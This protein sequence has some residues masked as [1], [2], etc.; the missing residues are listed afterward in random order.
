MPG[1]LSLLQPQVRHILIDEARCQGLEMEGNLVALLFRMAHSGSPAEFSVALEKLNKLIKNNAELTHSV[2]FWLNAMLRKRGI[3]I[4]LEGNNLEGDWAM[5]YK[6]GIELWME[7]K[8][9]EWLQEGIEQGIEQGIE[10]GK[11]HGAFLIFQ[12]LL[13]KRFGPLPAER[14]QLIR[15]SGTHQ[16]EIWAERLL[17]AQSLDEVFGDSPV[18]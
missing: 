1:S 14:L 8:Q 7:N 4:S 17:D 9:V 16:L 5:G 2:L 12:K 15:Q 6:W 13:A 3:V 10:R 18:H 11:G